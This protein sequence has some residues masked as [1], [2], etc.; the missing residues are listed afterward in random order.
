MATAEEKTVV[1]KSYLL[2]LDEDEAA[3]LLDLVYR[4]V[5]GAGAREIVGE[6][7][8]ALER[9]GV[10]QHRF[11]HLGSG[12]VTYKTPAVLAAEAGPEIGVRVRAI[13]KSAGGGVIGGQLGSLLDI[14]ADDADWPYYV[15]FGDKCRW[16]S[17]VEVINSEGD[18]S[19]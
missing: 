1:Q 12:I 15:D 6:I 14:D 19:K 18:S 10:D 7:W 3:F 11:A 16:V 4:R 8:Q 5:N 17:A 9:A 13:G 2:I